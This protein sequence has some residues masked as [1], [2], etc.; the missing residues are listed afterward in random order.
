MRDKVKN[1]FFY[2]GSGSPSH[3]TDIQ[4]SSFELTVVDCMTKMAHFWP[5]QKD[6]HASQL[7]NLMM[8]H[9]WKL[10][11]TPKTIV[12]DRGSVF[13]SQI[14][15]ELNKRLGIKLLPSTAYNPR[16]DGQSKIAN[17][18]VE[19]YLRHYVQH[20][21]HDWEG[22][23]PI[24]EFAYNNNNHVSSG[25][26]PFGANYGYHLSLG[27]IPLA[28]TVPPNSRKATGTAGAS[29]GGIEGMLGGGAR[30]DGDAIQPARR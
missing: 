10:H 2:P 15:R 28:G 11:G 26:S 20:H 7:A 5:C 24:A 1:H 30:G 16:T 25:T 19:Q 14:T 22:L 27:G 18:V 17:K 23:L 6:M 29:T 12:L 21:Q 8:R 13:I 9:V 4:P 3:C